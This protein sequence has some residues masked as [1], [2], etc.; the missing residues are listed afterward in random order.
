MAGACSTRTFDQSA[1]NSSAAMA[2]RPAWL[3]WP[4]SMCLETT[5]TQPSGENF[6]NGPK[7]PKSC[8]APMLSAWPITFGEQPTNRAPAESVAPTVRI[9]RREAPAAI[10][11]KGLFMPLCSSSLRRG[12][13]GLH[14]RHPSRFLYPGVD[15]LVGAATPEVAALGRIDLGQRGVG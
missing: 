1:S 5:V 14:C 12:G 15:A 11:L 4:N 7:A 2:A 9:S 13:R 3:P 6:R 10:A 8:G